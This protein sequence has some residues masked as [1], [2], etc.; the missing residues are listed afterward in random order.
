M[1]YIHIINCGKIIINNQTKQS[2][3]KLLIKYGGVGDGRG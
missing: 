1:K 2:S 3:L